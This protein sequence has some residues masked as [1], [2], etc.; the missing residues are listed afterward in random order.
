VVAA[1]GNEGGGQVDFPAGLAQA[2]SVAATDD[3]DAHAAFSNVNSD[4]EIAAPGMNVLSAKLGGGYVR[5]S[6]TS[7]ATPHVA[8]AAALL[9]GAEPSASA[10]TIRGRLD[11]AVVDLGPPGRDREFGFGRLDLSRIGR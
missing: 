11:R 10:S 5:D 2:V 7:M 6:G 9:W 8:A 1:A 3:R 4:V